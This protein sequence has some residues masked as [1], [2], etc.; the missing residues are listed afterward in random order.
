MK[1]GNT[2]YPQERCKEHQSDIDA[3]RGA[4]TECHGIY[5]CF[6]F[7]AIIHGVIVAYRDTIDIVLDTEYWI[8]D[9][10]TLAHL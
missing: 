9:T 10:C 6:T 4:E 3:K 2:R 1:H 7:A 8:L 5:P